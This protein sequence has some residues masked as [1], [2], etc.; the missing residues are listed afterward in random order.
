MHNVFVTDAQMRSSLAVIRSLGKK[1]L[2][3]TA[4]EETRF[5]TGF[6]SKYC[7]NRIVYPNPKKNGSE[8]V[9][10]LI[11]ELQ[12]KEYE[13]LFPIA[14][15]CLKPIMDN[16]K[17]I[18][19]YTSI[20]LPSKDILSK[21]YDKGMTLKIAIDNDIPCPKTY[22]FDT[23]EDLYNASEY[24]E[25]PLVIKPRI[26]SGSRGLY[27][28]NSLDELVLKFKENKQKYGKSLI[29]EYIPQRG[30]LGVY[31]L[32]NFDSE[33]RA[34]TVQRRIRSYPASGG[35]STLRETVNNE[36]SKKA[37]DIAFRL[38]KAMGWVG[39]AMVEFRIDSRDGVPKIM[40]VN[41]RFWGSLQLS[42]LSGV[43]FPYLLYKMIMQGD[44]DSVMEYKSGVKC[45]WLLPGD[46]LWFLTTP[47]KLQNLP[48]FLKIDTPFDIISKE[49]P[50]PTFGFMLASMRYVFDKD[51]WKFILRR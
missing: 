41:P 27:V 6:F 16:E 13:V 40:E 30:E 32:F 50:G 15:A 28:C 17:K 8:F 31:T 20:A 47:N 43:D 42:I 14:D 11:G 18:S 4:G 44:I 36:T 35:P 46:I 39:V 51:M 10:Y 12:K 26:S 49:D 38:L 24:L 22:F 9:D 2:K 3:V 29:Q 1:G 7:N 33:P 21:G 48:E 34:L 5:T 25:F 23:I 19:K 45:R 37:I